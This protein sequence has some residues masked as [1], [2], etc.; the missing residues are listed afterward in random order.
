MIFAFGNLDRAKQEKTENNY[1][2]AMRAPTSYKTFVKSDCQKEQK[3]T[4]F[5]I[6]HDY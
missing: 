3:N 4:D 2:H 5:K 6:S 1:C